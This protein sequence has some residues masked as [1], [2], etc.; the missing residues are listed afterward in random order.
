MSLELFE[1][2]AR[3]RFINDYKLPIQLF[4]GSYFDYFT[5]LYDGL[6]DISTYLRLYNNAIEETGSYQGFL[7]AYK[8]ARNIII[9]DL[10]DAA[11]A[12][13]FNNMSMLRWDVKN[14]NISKSS[15]F[16]LGNDGQ[17][18]TSIDISQANYQV[19]R[20]L[21]K[22]L[23]LH[24]NIYENMYDSLGLSPALKDYILNS[25]YFR[26]VIFGN[27]NPKRQ[28]AMQRFYTDKILD[29]IFDLGLEQSAIE[30]FSDDEIVV[31]GELK[32]DL[33]ERVQVECRDKLD[34]DVHIEVYSLDV[35]KTKFADAYIQRFLESDKIRIR[36]VPIVYF[37]AV[38]KTFMGESVGD[39]DL[40]FLY[41]NRVAQFLE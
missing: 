3:K 33:R 25:K 18:F 39:Y 10:N 2:S 37:A 14:R 40:R 26:Q 15:V 29:Y 35:F 6:F 30:T 9:Q 23:V 28:V 16:T 24:S 5:N 20:N 32:S 22:S 13:G 27:I 41:E 21:D 19:M 12:Y 4:Q 34:L 38:Y 36:K 1:N 17:I 7:E 8:D 11:D 31:S